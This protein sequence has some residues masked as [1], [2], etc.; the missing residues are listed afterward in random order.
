MFRRDA[1][2]PQLFQR[3]VMG[4]TIFLV[5]DLHS[6]NG[7]REVPNLTIL[8]GLQGQQVWRQWR[9]EGVCEQH[10]LELDL[11]MQTNHW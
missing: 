11:L 3:P 8:T 10:K 4:G 9:V 5:L 7:A 1:D 2:V 6:H